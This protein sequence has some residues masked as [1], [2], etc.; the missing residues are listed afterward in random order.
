MLGFKYT[1]SRTH[2]KCSRY[3]LCPVY[4]G[5]NWGLKLRKSSPHLT[6][7]KWQS[8]GSNLSR[9]HTK[10]HFFAKAQGYFCLFFPVFLSNGQKTKHL[11]HEPR[12]CYSRLPSHSHNPWKGRKKQGL[13]KFLGSPRGLQPGMLHDWTHNAW[14]ALNFTFYISLAT[15]AIHSHYSPNIAAPLF[16]PEKFPQDLLHRKRGHARSWRY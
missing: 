12:T 9:T 5:G 7:C 13:V 15:K 2:T 1:N 3:V 14:S 4:K 16:K 6:A 11:A 8:W 10:P